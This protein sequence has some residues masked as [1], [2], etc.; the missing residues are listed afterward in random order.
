MELLRRLSKPVDQELDCF[1]GG[2]LAPI[3]WVTILA[4]MLLAFVQ[5]LPGGV[6]LPTWALV[7]IFV[8]YNLIIEAVRRMVPKL[9][10]FARV[11]LLDLPVVG[12]LYSFGATPG[13]PLFVLILLI[14]AC[15][16]ASL[17]LVASLLYTSVAIG[18]VALIG[19]TLPMWRATAVEGRE[20]GVQLIVLAL[21]GLGA[22]LLVRRLALCCLVAEYCTMLS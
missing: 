17:N 9:Q 21:V 18:L 22:A 19:P 16:A 14:V 15:A 7:F 6:G 8:L 20:L 11:A 10:S 2:V 1:L 3:R 5:P 13:G 4:L 12:L